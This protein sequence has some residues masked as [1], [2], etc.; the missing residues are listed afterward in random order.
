M[1]EPNKT[2]AAQAQIEE[3]LLEAEL[4]ME[5]SIESLQ[6]DF[7]SIRTGRANPSLIERL[8][9]DYYGAPTP[10]QSIAAISAPEARLLVIQPYDKSSMADIERAIQKSELGLNPSNDGQVI[11]ISIPQLTEDRRKDFVKVVNHK[12]EEAR[13]SIR[14]IRRDE[15]DYLRRLEKEGHI[16]KDV[17][18]T[19]GDDVQKLTDKFTAKVD[20]LARKKEAEILEV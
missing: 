5:K 14:N 1:T 16:S 10:L 18:E 7:S 19:S 13:V 3:R 9:V 20:D 2:Q 12:A 4:R 15:M 17:V 8:N 11:R 6:K